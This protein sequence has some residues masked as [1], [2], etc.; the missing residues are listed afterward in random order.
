MKLILFAFGSR[1][2]V[3][4]LIALGRGLQGAGFEVALAAGT[5][6]EAWIRREGLG[7]EAITV[8]IEAEM[9]QE[10][11]VEWL[12]G[13]TNPRQELNNMK[14]MADSIA[15]KVADDIMRILHTGDVFISGLMTAEPLA[16]AAQRYG[17]R[18][19]FAPLSPFAVT[20]SG[21]AGLQSL[22]PNRHSAL[23]LWWGYLVQRLLFYALSTPSQVLHARMG[24]PPA[25][26][27]DLMRAL[28]RAN[29]VLGVSRLVTPPPP[30]WDAHIVT[31]GYWFLPAPAQWQPS[32]AL[33]H[34]LASGPPP[35]YVGFGSMSARSPQQTLSIILDA[36]KQSGQ[37][38]II[39]RGWAGLRADDVPPDVFVLY[40]APHAWLLPQ[41]SAI[42]HHGGSGTTGA[43]LRAGVPS[44][45]VWHI[46]DQ[47]YFG[48]RV[49]DLGAGPA[50]LS[51]PTLTAEGLA[52]AI[53]QMVSDRVMQSRA[54]EVGERIRAEDG[55]AAAVQAI[56]RWL[57]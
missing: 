32:P 36:L 7:Y 17:K 51:R 31:T 3:Q 33:A 44:C 20:R 35:V 15:P 34:F 43:G 22:L 23:N 52:S 10:Q 40:E 2:D 55:V 57:S 27:A 6:F 12:S 45:V 28:N 54:A 47:K 49:H 38:G 16:A 8:D 21:Q 30:D 14:R 56:T 13:S 46:G 26:A 4:P 48:Q 24:L 50:L 29:T 25:T 11:G 18:H 37:R 39:L 19:I 9:Q 42:V 1:G 5:N 41:M 53:R